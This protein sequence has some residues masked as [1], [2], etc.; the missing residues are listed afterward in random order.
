MVVGIQEFVAT[1]EQRSRL[2]ATGGAGHQD[3][4]NAGSG[5]GIGQGEGVGSEADGDAVGV[6]DDR[7]IYLFYSNDNFVYANVSIKLYAMG[8]LQLRANI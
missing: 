6:P 3:D 8:G 5:G 1:R 2:T 7:S 4:N